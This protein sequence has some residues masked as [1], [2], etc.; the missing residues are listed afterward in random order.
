MKAS[1]ALLHAA[2][3][4]VLA[5]RQ[6]GARG[7][8]QQQAAGQLYSFA[9]CCDAGGMVLMRMR[10]R[11]HICTYIYDTSSYTSYRLLL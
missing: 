6:Q 4:D 9:Y 10:A 3:A 5:C 7:G 8:G 11:C 1:V 2:D